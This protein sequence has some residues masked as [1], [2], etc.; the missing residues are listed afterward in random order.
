MGALSWASTSRKSS[1]HSGADPE[2]SVP[3]QRLPG[4]LTF[5]H[6]SYIFCRI[7]YGNQRRQHGADIKERSYFERNAPLLLP[8]RRRNQDEDDFRERQGQEH[9]RMRKVQACR[10]PSERLQVMPKP[11]L[12]RGFFV[13]T[14]LIIQRPFDL[15]P[16]I[17]G[18]ALS[19]SRFRL[20]LR[21]HALF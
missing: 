5:P 8:V 17:L 21:P 1:A 20:V 4:Q 6:S 13:Y 10:A 19:G 9:C 12:L 2:S 18:P 11:P 3:S 14:A 7:L 16:A 15:L